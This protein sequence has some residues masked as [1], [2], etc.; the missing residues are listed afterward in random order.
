VVETTD[1]QPLMKL[2]QKDNQAP[3]TFTFVYSDTSTPP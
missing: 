3:A 1:P 2:P